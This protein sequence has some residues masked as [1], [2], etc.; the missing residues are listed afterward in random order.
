MRAAVRALVIALLA[1][2]GLLLPA[3]R[4]SEPAAV[5]PGEAASRA[6]ATVPLLGLVWGKVRGWERR[7][8]GWTV[9][10]QPAHG[11]WTV[12]AWVADD[13]SILRHQL[14]VAPWLPGARLSRAAALL[15][16]GR[17]G[18]TALAAE[19]LG[20]RDWEFGSAR[21]L[22]AL[23]AGPGLG[24]QPKGR[25]DPWLA[26]LAG[27]VLAGAVTRTVLPGVPSRGWRRATIG[28][29]V[30]LLGML[31]WLTSLGARFFRAGVR[32]WVAEVTV[33]TVAALILA[34][35]VVGAA[36]Y[37]TMCGRPTTWWT[38]PGA[39]ALGS[40]AGHAWPMPMT[41]EIGGLAV[42]VP[43]F[44]ALAVVAGWIGTL[45]ADGL[46]ELAAL[47][48]SG[49]DFVVVLVALTA[50]LTPGPSLALALAACVAASRGRGEGAFVALAVAW[51]WVTASFAASCAWPE[52]G[53]DT[54]LLLLATWTTVA[55]WAVPARPAAA[56]AAEQ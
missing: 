20:R 55:I 11:A 36:R 21:L 3:K 16:A 46:R 25:P 39:V 23:R 19:R 10:W 53:R 48:A 52:A 15:V 12:R 43:A 49:R 24:Q 27:L 6:E 37:P 29:S 14:D 7:H 32:P 40:M 56:P 28:A 35:V 54:L 9:V 34:A 38:V 33:G 42:R 31:P 4:P 50:L 44:V 51:G 8:D 1:G 30:A 5:S 45:A 17:P 13:A 47:A 26:V 41:A 2:S 22:G 18:E